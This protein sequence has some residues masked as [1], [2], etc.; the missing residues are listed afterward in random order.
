MHTDT[1]IDKKLK[2]ELLTDTFKLLRLDT[3]LKEFVSREEKWKFQQL[4]L[5]GGKTDI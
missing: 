5:N 4:A 2:Q 1:M 3:T